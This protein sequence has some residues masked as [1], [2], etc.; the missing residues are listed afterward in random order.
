MTK[1]QTLGEHMTTLYL[2]SDRKRCAGKFFDMPKGTKPPPPQQSSLEQMW[3][4]KQR[5]EEKGK[6]EKRD[7][8]NVDA[9][10]TSLIMRVFARP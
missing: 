4:P 8:M 9:P 2:S 5:R 6:D 1:Q 7:E 10:G 3:K